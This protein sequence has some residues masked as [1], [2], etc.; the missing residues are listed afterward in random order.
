MVGSTVAP[1]PIGAA[2]KY[3]P[4]LLQRLIDQACCFNVFAVPDRK[5]SDASVYAPIQGRHVVGVRA[6]QAL[7][8]FDM[9]LD[10]SS[11]KFGVRATTA[12][13]ESA[14]SL[15]LHWMMIPH[16]YLALPDREPPQTRLDPCSSQRFVMKEMTLSFGDGRDGFRSFGTGRTFPMKGGARPKLVVA[17][18]GNITEGLGKFKG[19]A[20][21]FTLCGELVADRGFLGHIVVRIADPAGSLTVPL[22]LPPVDPG[23]DPD[24]DATYLLWTAQKGK[25]LDQ[26][27]T[28]SL[29]PDGKMRGLNIPTQLKRCCIGFTA[30]QPDGFQSMDYRAGEVIGREIGFG[31]GSYPDAPPTGTPLS[32][33]LFEGV[34][35]YSF[36]SPDGR[37]SGAI[38]TNVIE[39][40]RFDLL[41]PGAPGEVAWRFGFFGPIM[42]GTGCFRGVEGVFY[43][44][45]TSVFK[46]PPG[47][48]VITHLYVARL[49]DPDGR[50]RA[51]VGRS[52]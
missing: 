40:R 37:T 41:L 6:K 20:G 48:H 3:P 10:L 11:S 43:G 22:D 52:R 45:S 5:R 39:G 23:P 51:A 17:A 31:R 44:A 33:Y 8:R 24:P 13:G 29:G 47:D 21:N 14:G 2:E 19:H 46:P 9:G 25:G 18:V 42:L 36:F 32:P 28:A 1:E 50:F 49:N 12:V 16:E 38:T 30:T 4:D 35:Q 27:N 15:D 34:A 26:E 7:H